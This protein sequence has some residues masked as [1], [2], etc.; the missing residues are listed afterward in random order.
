MQRSV[1]TRVGDRPRTTNDIRRRR[2]L[3]AL[4]I[5]PLLLLVTVPAHAQEIGTCGD[6]IL[7][8]IEACDDGNLLDGDC[9]S[10][11]C[12]VEPAGTPCADDGNPC[13]LDACDGAGAC[14]HPASAPSLGFAAE[15]DTYTDD[16]LFT[17][18]FGGAGPLVVDGSPKRR[19]FLR[20]TA[21]GIGERAI[22]QAILRMRTTTDP[23]AG[24]PAG[25]TIHTVA[26][27]G[28]DELAVTH[29]NRPQMDAAVLDN[30]G[31]VTIDQ[32]VDFDVTAAIAGD[33]T[34]SFGI[35]P[36]LSDGAR[37]Y[38]REA[39][40]GG[41]ELILLLAE[42]CDDG[43]ACTLTDLCLDGVCTGTD[44]V[45][46]PAPAQCQDAGVCDPATGL[47]SEP[48]VSADGSACED[49]DLCTQSD[50]CQDGVC[51]TGAGIV[52]VASD[53]CHDAGVCDPATGLC[54]D[55]ATAE[56]TACD[57][58]SLCTATDMCEDGICVGTD[59]VICSAPAECLDAGVCD[60]ATGLCSEPT[61]SAD[62]SPCE[63][64]DLCTTGSTCASSICM[65]G[66]PL[67]C[68][69]IDGCHD[70]GLCDPESGLCS[71][72]IKIDGTACD[73]GNAC[74]GSDACQAGVCTGS[75]PIVCTASDQCHDT[76]MCNP[77]TGLCSDPAKAND[78]GCDDGNACTRSDACQAGVCTG[79]N[80]IVCTASDQCHAAGVCNP[81][82]GLCS[83]PS[84]ANGA[85]C[86]DGN[87]CTRSD[88]CQAGV[89]TG[90]NGIV[91]TASDQCHA[92]GVCD[93]GT[94]RCSSPAKADGTACDDDD[95]CSG[96]DV[97]VAG[98][99]S[100]TPMSDADTDGF[101]D[102]RDICP[103]VPNADQTDTD[104]DG[105]GDLCQCTSPAPGRCVVGG[106][107]VK[108]DCF[109]EFLSPAPPVLNKKG[110]KMKPFIRCSDGDAACDLDGARD[111][112]CTVGVAVCFGNSDPRLPGCTA[113]MIR[114]AE[115]V[116]P[117]PAKLANAVDAANAQR[118]ETT[119][120]D[121]GLEIQRHGTVI[122]ESVLPVGNDLCS[123]L[124]RLSV[125]G[126]RGAKKSASKTFVLQ[127]KGV[128]GRAD[129]DTL[130]VVC[131]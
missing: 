44:T 30:A 73:D 112:T 122:A 15:A 26:D 57:D 96:G 52:C 21:S 94:G 5:L 54:S 72:P 33:G 98:A 108:T 27:N 93:P 89:C 14:A 39:A 53:Q 76:G 25:G 58:G 113:E 36:E 119:L 117:D 22:R 107:T 13:T 75:N 104:G 3:P 7:D 47:C 49:G 130:N 4:W 41:P 77:A 131:E 8:P 48:T 64:G 31:P 114:S 123:P 60:P 121:L 109:V 65:T 1:C 110:T 71:A 90:S 118:F 62:G 91:C 16:E 9:C 126:P 100:G 28:W 78:T 102:T 19:I 29:M 88:T 20:F 63:D 23:S 67:T 84:K 83:D 51:I 32:V 82:T 92:A 2:S 127:A 46:C 129:K 120:G 56:G 69:P 24:S 6:G 116:K 38:S 125:P 105:I 128:S 101:C 74:T 34:Y 45:I 50:S 95:L 61:V 11:A 106:G 99:C 10:S 103:E 111:G 97:C 124:V 12:S 66:T 70:A 37:Y 68:T 86:D 59:A 18:N 80:A 35:Q 55:P 42:P 17:M 79:S 85:A 87:A 40:T 115:I 81:A 43:S